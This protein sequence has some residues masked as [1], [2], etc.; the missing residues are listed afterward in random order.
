MQTILI[1]DDDE[2]IRALIET[3]LESPACRI[4]LAE[5]GDAALALAR[6]ELPDL[7]ILDWMMPK[8]TGP[9]IAER[10]HCD[11]LT[12][13]I[14]IVLLTGMACEENR[15]RGLATGALAYLI[16]PFSPLQL[17]QIVQQVLAEK[18]EADGRGTEVAV[19]AHR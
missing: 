11:P 1:A 8:L 16:K 6:R 13:G 15:Q 9:E 10:L 2:G 4:L 18:G 3:T 7:V 14:P 5:D 17:L 12:A 19:A